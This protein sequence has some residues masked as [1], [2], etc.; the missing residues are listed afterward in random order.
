[1]VIVMT[2]TIAFTSS[3]TYQDKVEALPI[4]KYMMQ[5]PGTDEPAWIVLEKGNKFQFNRHISLSYQ[6]RGEYF[7]QKNKL[8]LKVS[9]DELYRFKI[10]GHKL[11]F[12]SGQYTEGIIDVGAVFELTQNK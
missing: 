3:C 4:G 10:S 11:M 6:P 1:M 8:I 7:V 2:M 9:N 5:S 12:E